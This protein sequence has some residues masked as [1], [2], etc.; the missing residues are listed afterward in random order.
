[1]IGENE[2]RFVKAIVDHLANVAK[3]QEHIKEHFGIQSYYDEDNETLHLV[4]E[5][6]S[7]NEGLALASAKEY[8]NR[9]IDETMLNVVYGM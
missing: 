4:S 1:M 6:L 5:N 7:I 9:Q 3:V 8:V 2:K